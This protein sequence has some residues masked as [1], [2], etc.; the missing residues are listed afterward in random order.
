ML[1]FLESLND[2]F[3][4]GYLFVISRKHCNTVLIKIP[5]KFVIF[6]DL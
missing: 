5:D 1:F 2:L 4:R 3:E 6:D